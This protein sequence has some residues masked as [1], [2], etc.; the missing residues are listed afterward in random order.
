MRLTTTATT[1]TTVTTTTVTTFAI[2]T[3]MPSFS[4]TPEKAPLPSPPSI[5]VKHRIAKAW[6]GN[7]AL[8]LKRKPKL[9]SSRP[10]LLFLG[11]AAAGEAPEDFEPTLMAWDPAKPDDGEEVSSSQELPSSASARTPLRRLDQNDRS[12]HMDIVPR[13]LAPA[14]DFATGSRSPLDTARK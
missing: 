6:R 9:A 5:K 4:A 11:V 7:R 1:A 3:T 2:A 13:R 8:L 12:D 10:A 14:F